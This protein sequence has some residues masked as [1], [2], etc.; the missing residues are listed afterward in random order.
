M[1][2]KEIERKLAENV[3]ER[4]E[5]FLKKQKYEKAEK[6]RRLLN[7]KRESVKLQTQIDHQNYLLEQQRLQDQKEHAR[8]DWGR[9]LQAEQQARENV[10]RDREAGLTEEQIRVKYLDSK[11]RIKEFNKQS[12]EKTEA[13]LKGANSFL[14]DMY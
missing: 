14:S 2:L 4:A 8:S 12:I 11:A 6:E 9:T 7:K 5:L 3:K 1:D 10:Q 13:K